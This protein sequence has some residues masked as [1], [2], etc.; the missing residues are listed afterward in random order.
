M[1]KILVMLGLAGAVYV[2]MT[3][4]D[5]CAKPRKAAML[6]IPPAAV[7][8]CPAGYTAAGRYE[9]RAGVEAGY[10]FT[11]IHYTEKGKPHHLICTQDDG[12]QDARIN[13]SASGA[14]PEPKK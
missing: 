6:S 11:I 1:K 4:M 10:G 9:G 3:L 13:R 5:G 12:K 7:A 14:I 2:A 8:S